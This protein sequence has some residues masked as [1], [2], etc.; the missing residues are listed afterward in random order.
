M[1]GPALARLVAA[2]LVALHL[3]SFLAA[4]GADLAWR[5]PD[6]WRLTGY[7]IALGLA[8]CLGSLLPQA[9]SALGAAALRRRARLLAFLFLPLP[10]LLALAVALAE[11]R[12][13]PSAAHALTLLQVVVLLLADVLGVEV[14]ALWGGLV[15]SLVAAGAGGLPA[16]VGLGGF[17]VLAA[18]FLSL[19]H[20]VRRLLEWPGSAAPGLTGVLAGA[21]LEVAAPFFLLVTA[22]VVLPDGVE[23]GSATR[24]AT[25][26]GGDTE[27]AYQWLALVALAGGGITTLV[28]RW[29]RGMG[30]G[31]AQPLVE[32]PDS[33]VVGEEILEPILPDD[34]RYAAARGRII[35]AYLRFRKRAAEAGLRVERYLTP[36]EIQRR[37]RWD[38]EALGVL[39]QLFMD[40]RY[41]PDEPTQAAVRVA[42]AASR[43]VCS[44]LRGAR[45]RA[46]HR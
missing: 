25:A 10:G 8:L 41:G 3:L 32:V 46:T 44:G 20:V 19:D 16:V 43:E 26:V 13:A 27:R 18:I 5:P 40:A 35:R 9:L 33:H 37:V 7:S 42:E 6:L 45:A 11:P 12:L 2:R 30:G 36:R 23:I 39:T 15:L 29:L 34:P 14:L 38:G 22:L 28:L 4:A 1:G 24:G 17:L 21:L 31:D